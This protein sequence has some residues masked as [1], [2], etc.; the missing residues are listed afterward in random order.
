MHYR[1]TKNYVPIV[2]SAAPGVS[3]PAVGNELG[4]AGTVDVVVSGLQTIGTVVDE[5]PTSSSEGGE[6][7]D[8]VAVCS[9]PAGGTTTTSQAP[10]TNDVVD[11]VSGEVPIVSIGWVFPT[12]SVEVL[13]RLIVVV[14]ATRFNGAHSSTA[15]VVVLAG[16]LELEEVSSAAVVEETKLFSTLIVVELGSTTVGNVVVEVA[17]EGSE[18]GGVELEG[19]ELGASEVGGTELESPVD[20][21]TELGTATV[22]SVVEGTELLLSSDC[23]AVVVD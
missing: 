17:S 19:T 21:I 13:T 12:S 16:S 5:T 1:S 9:N 23:G 4:D 6:I 18:L 10:G 14:D 11:V 15:C 22:P 7:L 2:V 20:G 8:D 3:G